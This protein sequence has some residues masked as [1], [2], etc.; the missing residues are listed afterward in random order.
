MTVLRAIRTRRRARRVA[1][2]GAGLLSV[3]F[4]IVT[5]R[6]FVWPDLQPLPKHADAIIELGGA[7]MRDRDRVALELARERT[8]TVL[9]QSTRRGDTSCLPPVAGVRIMCFYANPNTTRGEARWIGATA[10]RQ[11]WSSVILVTTPD[12]AW[13]ADLRVSRCFH[14][15]VY[16]ATANLPAWEWF[17]QIPYQLLASIKALAL[18]RTC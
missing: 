17:R 8:A 7:G 16:N 9:V 12:Q 5:A 1:W 10:N 4:A 13:R 18:E 15:K 14:G 3:A 6:L 2:I 11:H